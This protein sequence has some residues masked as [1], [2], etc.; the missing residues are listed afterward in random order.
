[1]SNKPIFTKIML[2]IVVA[3][4]C[5]VL[6][7]LMAFLFGSIDADVFDFSNLNISNM[8]P[9]IVVGG[10]ISCVIVGLLVLVL[11]KDVFIKVKDFLFESKNDRGNEK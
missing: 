6:T 8:W 2:V 11:A 7:V 4:V 5:L 3:L 9:V 1:M 10:F